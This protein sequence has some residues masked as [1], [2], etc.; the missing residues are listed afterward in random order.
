MIEN[1]GAQSTTKGILLAWR[2]EESKDLQDLLYECSNLRLRGTQ[3]PVSTTAQDRQ[4]L[5]HF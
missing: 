1:F 2:P 3:L 5:R 4:Q